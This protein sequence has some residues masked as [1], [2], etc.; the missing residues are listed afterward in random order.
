MHC[1]YI[2]QLYMR[3][4]KTNLIELICIYVHDTCMHHTCKVLLCIVQHQAF[5]N[6]LSSLIYI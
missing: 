2:Y 1:I 3:L 4:S 5:G 6:P